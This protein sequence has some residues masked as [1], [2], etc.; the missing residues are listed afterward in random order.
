MDA[1]YTFGPYGTATDTI[2]PAQ[3]DQVLRQIE[4]EAH[5]H[6][7]GAGFTPPNTNDDQY[8]HL[9][10]LTTLEEQIS[11]TSGLGSPG[12]MT[13]GSIC[14][15]P[16]PLVPF[17]DHEISFD[18]ASNLDNSYMIFPDL[19]TPI[20]DEGF[21]GVLGFDLATV[22]TIP[23]ELCLEKAASFPLSDGLRPYTSVWD[24]N[25]MVD[26]PHQNS[27]SAFTSSNPPAAST[28]SSAPEPSSSTPQ[29][30]PRLICS[31]CP[32]TFT[33]KSKL[34]IHTNK[35][36]KPFKCT[37]AGCSF[38]TAE[39]KSLQRH[40]AARSKWDNRHALA[41]QQYG[42]PVVTYQCTEKEC[43]YSTTR[44]DN[45]KRHKATCHSRPGVWR[46]ERDGTP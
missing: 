35:H 12:S 27:D 16:S 38:I 46:A 18:M 37:A 28:A 15:D 17:L 7:A 43:K 30:T 26:N 25:A 41:A 34:K 44:E 20:S 33:E 21:D 36:T 9:P 3:I 32:A 5:F 29:Q 42:L 8:T 13:T 19:M 40:L 23:H 24:P 1:P 11:P 45:M 10:G 31:H 14:T 6:A 39:K 22:S 4:W 2:N